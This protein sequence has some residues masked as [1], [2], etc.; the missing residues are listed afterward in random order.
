MDWRDIHGWCDFDQLYKQVVAGA[1]PNA[2]FV[3]VGCWFG[4]SAALMGTLIRDSGTPITFYAV[5]PWDGRSEGEPLGRAIYTPI[6]DLLPNRD[7]YPVF[8]AN[9][10]GCGV[11]EFV[12]PVRRT[13]VDAAVLF[14]D[15]SLDFVFLDAAHDTP[16]VMADL[17]AWW[18][19]I[20]LG[21]ILAGH[22]LAWPSVQAALDAFF[23]PARYDASGSCWIREK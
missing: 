9:L 18:P 13:S 15:G 14:A 7:V 21:G 8:A 12:R 1:R 17:R 11:S 4:K 2:L 22:D 10:E 20:R 19:K 5:D 16:S 6:V 3:E 23:G